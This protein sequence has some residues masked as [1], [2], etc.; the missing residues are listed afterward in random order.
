MPWVRR[1]LEAILM[2]L[3]VAAGSLAMA[4]ITAAINLCSLGWETLSR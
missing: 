3:L 1:P 4:A 2:L